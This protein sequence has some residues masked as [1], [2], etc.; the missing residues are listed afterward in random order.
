MWLTSIKIKAQNPFLHLQAR[1]PFHFFPQLLIWTF[2]TNKITEQNSK[3]IGLHILKNYVL[4]HLKILAFSSPKI[5]LDFDH[6]HPIDMKL[7]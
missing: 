3:G 2:I 6:H 7:K 1:I 4:K 5:I